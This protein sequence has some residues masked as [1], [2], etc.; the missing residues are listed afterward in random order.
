MGETERER[1]REREKDRTNGRISND[2]NIT[3][4]SIKMSEFR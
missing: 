2:S 4:F 3:T 1:E